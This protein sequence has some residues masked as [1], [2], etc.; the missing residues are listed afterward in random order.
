MSQ[1][2]WKWWLIGIALA[3]WLGPALLTAPG[4][5]IRVSLT[6]DRSAWWVA[7][8]RQRISAA[9]VHY[10]RCVGPILTVFL[11]PEPCGW[12]RLRRDRNVASR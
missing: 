11:D 6:T 4:Y 9:G 3:L 2:R 1:G 10:G 5:P 8:P 7:L 12:D